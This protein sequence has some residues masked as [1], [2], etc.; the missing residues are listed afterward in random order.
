[1]N[2]L[3][4]ILALALA[5]TGLAGAQGEVN[6]Y[7]HRHYDT[8]KELFAQFEKETGIKVNV[9]KA[10][11]DELIKRLELEGKN[12]PADVLVT[13]DAGR[14]YRAQEKGL[15]Q[16]VSSAALQANIP[17]HLREQDGH[18]FGLTTRARVIVYSQDR[19]K[20]AQLS[21]YEA[22]TDAQW[23]GKI[24]IR[25][26]QNI[27]NQSLMASLIAHHGKADARQWAAGMV[28]N[29]ARPPKGNDRD[30]I[31]AVAGGLADLAI[32]NTYY[33]GLL[34]NSADPA[35]Q[36]VAR[37]VGIYF[38]NQAGR[39]THIN[40]SGAGVTKHAKNRANAIKLLEFLSAEAAQERFAQAN[41]EYPVNPNVAW[42]EQLQAWGDFKADD[43]SMSELGAHNRDAVLLFDMVGWR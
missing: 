33:V 28:D 32:V 27:Y 12:S 3:L 42:S 8:D 24:V 6:V 22:L 29:F 2:H 39:G 40:I 36:Q 30:Q 9:V 14:L 34:L 16:P 11:A 17:A 1:M 20:P 41:Y 23:K 7:T 37:Q 4:T 5:L 38:P 26:S 31:K 21:T 35:E 43:L 18:W 25:S 13:V 15:L 10:K 19:V